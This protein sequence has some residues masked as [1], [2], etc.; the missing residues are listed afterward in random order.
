MKTIAIIGPG[1]MGSLFAAYLKNAGQDVTLIDHDTKRASRL[2]A[3]GITVKGVRGTLSIKVPVIADADWL[4][5]VDLLMVC[6][7]AFN[8]ENALRQH[9]D[10]VG[11]ETS[12]LSLQNGLGNIEALSRV[13][14][15]KNIIAGTTTVGANMLNPGMIHHAGDGDTIIG[16]V[17][18]QKSE[19]P[20]SVARV[21]QSAGFN[22]LVSNEVLQAIWNKLL[23]NVGINALSAIVGVRNGI[24]CEHGPT[25]T[26][27]K[28]AVKEAVSIAKQQG[29]D[30]EI[31]TMQDKVID[32]AKKTSQNRSSM[33]V[34]VQMGR[35]TEIDQINGAIAGLG[36]APIN[37]T[38]TM[39]VHALEATFQQRQRLD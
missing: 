29:L 26:L 25:R 31:E 24:L 22:V 5:P 39:L 7:K 15:E 28:E 30:F 27:M 14:S 37:F 38:L 12:V 3:T 9:L 6:V 10:L 11:P 18:G 8:T 13:V 34:D 19:K 2:N 1:A 36:H 33:L 20:A 16:P 32:V 4:D 21:L 17:T 35:Q 23:I